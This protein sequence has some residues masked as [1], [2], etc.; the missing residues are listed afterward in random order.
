MMLHCQSHSDSNCAVLVRPID[1]LHTRTFGR[2]VARSYVAF[3]LRIWEEIVLI[4]I[5]RETF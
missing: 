4:P 2:I 5:M 1:V 3:R